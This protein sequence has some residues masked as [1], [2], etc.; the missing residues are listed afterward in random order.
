VLGLIEEGTHIVARKPAVTKPLQSRELVGP[1]LDA[2]RRHECLLVPGEHGA[3]P[4]QVGHL[5]QDLLQALQ[6]VGH[7]TPRR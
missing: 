4:T 6:L 3:G 2:S 7:S 1:I 5:A